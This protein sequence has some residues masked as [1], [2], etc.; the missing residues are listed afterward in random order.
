M[1]ARHILAFLLPFL[2]LAHSAG[3]FALTCGAGESIRTVTVGG[4]AAD[5]CVSSSSPDYSKITSPSS[6]VGGVISQAGLPKG[7]TPSKISISGERGRQVKSDL[8]GVEYSWAVDVS[9]SLG[10]RYSRTVSASYKVSRFFQVENPRVVLRVIR[11]AIEDLGSAW[12]QANGIA[13]GA[14][15]PLDDGHH[16]L[17]VH[18]SSQNVPLPDPTDTYA[19]EL[20]LDLKS[21]R[22]VE[23]PNAG[24]NKPNPDKIYQRRD[25]GSG[26][27]CSP[28]HSRYI[29][30]DRSTFTYPELQRVVIYKPGLNQVSSEFYGEGE[31]PV[32]PCP[33]GYDQ[34][35]TFLGACDKITYPDP[36]C[37]YGYIC[38]GN[39]SC[40]SWVELTYAQ[41]KSFVMSN[42]DL[43]NSLISKIGVRDSKFIAYGNS[44]GDG[45]EV[46]WPFDSPV[47]D[48][49]GFE[50]PFD[51]APLPEG[52][53][54]VVKPEEKP[55]SI[56]WSL[57][58]GSDYAN[59][60]QDPPLDAHEVVLPALAGTP[61]TDRS[62]PPP[63]KLSFSIASVSFE[64]DF[65]FSF[66]CDWFNRV[67]PLFL[68]AGAI[69]AISIFVRALKE[70]K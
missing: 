54:A 33:A 51:G 13:S 56:D 62:C 2:L 68:S 4:Q 61:W 1:Y 46:D 66:V 11:A 6:W 47:I 63:R 41:V 53:T 9:D 29:V 55:V 70:K 44:P 19:S 5:V 26:P 60:G 31:R 14:S 12:I 38:H 42:P 27:R 58:F 16:P 48:W 3:A 59:E 69:F 52:E 20:V 45:Q 7:V 50:Q 67:R 43:L 30:R 18:N 49:G 65:T 22:M 39:I 17:I 24:L 21:G 25:Y 15:V 35:I 23:P 32:V 57:L 10:N 36:P 34:T 8:S 37:N 64:R 28:S 40:T